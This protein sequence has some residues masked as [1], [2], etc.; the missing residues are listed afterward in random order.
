MSQIFIRHNLNVVYVMYHLHNSGYIYMLMY[1][2][3]RDFYIYGKTTNVIQK[4]GKINPVMYLSQ[5]LHHI[6]NHTNYLNI[7]MFLW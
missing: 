3:L 2:Q 4:Q 5:Q 1:I 7:Y 6:L